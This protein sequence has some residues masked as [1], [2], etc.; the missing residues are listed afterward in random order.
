MFSSLSTHAKGV[1]IT[2][3]GVLVLS[4]DGLLIRLIT[5]DTLTI[6]F[7]RGLFYSTSMFLVLT[8]FYKGKIIDAFFAIG[9]PGL[10]LALLYFIGNLAFIYS[11][12]HTAVA[13]T[14]FIVSTTP[15]FAALISWIIL[16]QRVDNRTW[17][18]IVI[19]G[20]GIV[21]ICGGASAMPQAQLGNIS[22]LL[23][24]FTLAA[25]FT[26]I[27][28]YREK[29]LLPSFVLGGFL[30]ALVLEPFVSPSQTSDSDLFYFFL[31]GFYHAAH[32]SQFDVHWP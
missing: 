7:W 11:I 30:M 21:I 28:R 32:R 8:V 12:T 15:L 1:I 14:L 26:I 29:D 31:D 16:K 25:S 22:G 27:S 17:I 10:V 3:L 9:L 24:A 19:A 20:I 23:G 6:T 18:A 4:P 2:A 13:N 5:A